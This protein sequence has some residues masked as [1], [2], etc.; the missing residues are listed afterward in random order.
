MLE[1]AGEEL[2]AVIT[3]M[4][5]LCERDTA[6]WISQLLSALEHMHGC[7]IYHR[8]LKPENLLLDG[9]PAMLPP[10]PSLRG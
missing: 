9:E 6:R 7:G 8:D 10:P 4:D 5:E 3:R 1:L 2:F